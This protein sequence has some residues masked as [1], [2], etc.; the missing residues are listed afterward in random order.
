MRLLGIADRPGDTDDERLRKRAGVSAGYITIVAPLLV[1]IQAQGHLV[2][3]ILGVGWS[4]YSAVD[5]L[6]LARTR[7]F[8]PYVVAL[9][10]SGVVFVP[11]VTAL[12]GGVTGATTGI[13]WAFLVPAYAIMALGPRRATVWFVAFLVMVMGM[14]VVDPF[15]H[16]AIPEVPY[17]SRLAAQIANAVL[18]LSIVFLLLRYTDLRR[19]AAEARADELLTN[20]IPAS[21]AARLRHGEDRIAEAYPE[22]TI[23]FADIVESTP[24]ERQTDPSTVVALL[25]RLFTRFDQLAAACAMEKIK[26]IGDA[27]MAAAGAPLPLADHPG[28]ALRLATG[29]LEVVANE[30]ETG[31][32]GLQVRIGLASG[33]VVGGVIGEQRA[34]FDLW[35]DTVN[36]ASRM[37]STGVPGR[38]Q[39]AASTWQLLRDRYSFEPREVEIKGMGSMTAYLLSA[40]PVLVG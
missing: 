21:I 23:L 26:T 11:A 8:E 13:G 33:P 18:P 36:L 12:G 37:E 35:G 9:L 29:I 20:A 19:R 25:D 31:G 40:S 3:L 39:V 15:L 16:A 28:A 30:R 27:Y 5:L 6:V 1:P 17:P 4:A 2:A 22:T 7:R 32:I 38:I 10:V 14:T 34:A 24:W